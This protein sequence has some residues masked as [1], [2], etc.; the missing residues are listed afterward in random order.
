MRRFFELFFLLSALGSFFTLVYVHMV[1][2]QTP[3]R[4]LDRV[5]DT[6]PRDGVLRVE[7]LPPSMLMAKDLLA[8]DRVSPEP[9]G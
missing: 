8:F 5:R 7:I 6:W 2:T 1:F 3:A 4:C 9:F